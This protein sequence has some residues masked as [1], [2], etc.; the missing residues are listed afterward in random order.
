MFLL[1]K[2]AILCLP[3]IFLAIYFHLTLQS[4]VFNGLES[5]SKQGFPTDGLRRPVPGILLGED[6]HKD[7]CFQNLKLKP[8]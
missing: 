6:R 5:K 4:S 7:R 3:F 2:A 1:I 8:R